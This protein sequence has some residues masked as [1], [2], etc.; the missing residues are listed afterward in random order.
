LILNNR[1][2]AIILVPDRREGDQLTGRGFPDRAVAIYTKECQQM[3]DRHGGLATRSI[4]KYNGISRLSADT[5][6]QARFHY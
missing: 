5:G 1:I 3:G 6:A 4:R 2:E